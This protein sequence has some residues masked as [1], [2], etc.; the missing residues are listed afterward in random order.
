MS[1]WVNRSDLLLLGNVEDLRNYV[2]PA[3]G[4]DG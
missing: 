1:L 3:N 2:N 4:V